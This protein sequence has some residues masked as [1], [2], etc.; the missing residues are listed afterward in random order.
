M[1][2]SRLLPFSLLLTVCAAPVLAQ[3]LPEKAPAAIQS[4][5]ST[6]P[7]SANPNFS[8]LFPSLQT[9]EAPAAPM[10][11]IRVEEYSPQPAQF[12]VSRLLVIRP[13]RESPDDD[14]VCYTMRSYKVARDNPH[15]DSTH[16]VGSSTC[17]PAARFHT[18]TIE[19]RTTQPAP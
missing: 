3:S 4:A 11:R 12:S 1:L 9:E 2:I 8:F 7:N 15:S 16:A 14:N 10:D 19:L 6:P 13:D 5:D 18:R 17:Q